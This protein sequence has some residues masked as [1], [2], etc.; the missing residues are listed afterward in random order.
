MLKPTNMKSYVYIF[1]IF[2]ASC[3]VPKLTEQQPHQSLPKQYTDKS[4]SVFVSKPED[5]FVSN[6]LRVL[7]DS[8]LK[9]NYDF[10][11]A[12]Q[13]IELSKAYLLQSR[14]SQ[15][16]QVNGLVMPGLR[17]FGL[18]TMDGAGNIV[19]EME[20]GKLVPINL[21]DFYGG[22]QASWEADLWGK[23]KAGRRAA[24]FR[25][26][27][28]E[29]EL[30]LMQTSLVAQTATWYYELLASDEELRML[31]RSIQLQDEALGFIKLQKEAGRV[32]E[33]AVQQFDA[34]LLSL[35]ALRIEV[36]QQI[37]A[38]ETSLSQLMCKPHQSIK[39]DSLFFDETVLRKINVGIPA[40]LLVARPDVRAAE[41]ELMASQ[42]YVQMARKSFLP[43]L[44]I[45]G[46]VGL[47]AYRPGLLGLFP[48]SL[49]Y[50]FVSGLTAPLLNKRGLEA[51]FKNAETGMNMAFLQ[52][53]KTVMASFNEV[54]QHIVQLEKAQ[55]KYTLKANE[56][57]ILQSSIEVSNDLFKTG[58][59]NYLDVLL[60]T[61]RS[62]LSNIER[63]QIRKEQ[64]VTVTQLY[65]ALGGGWNK[66]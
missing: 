4:D 55:Q 5:L 24:A 31:D 36:E 47:Q 2:F 35:K 19:T 48:E 58:K 33:L 15:I 22:L 42:A 64:L 43:S 52:Y 44:M 34:Q 59:A 12:I 53:E 30:R 29:E 61:Q 45:T 17:R 13:R 37:L 28:N 7:V 26:K 50:A 63:I 14:A 16:P 9:H 23:L 10:K 66:N 38:L 39:R 57:S 20:R 54:K 18:Y 25:V 60:A 56:A 49:A 51:N 32:N 3:A 46:N 8:V 6:K 11:I 21:P 27:A 65:R 40:Q 41:Y 62:V 1:F